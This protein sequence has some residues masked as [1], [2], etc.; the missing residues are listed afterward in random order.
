MKLLADLHTHSTNSRFRHG[1]NSIEEMAIEANEVG[2]VE[3]GVTDHG[4]Q[5]FFRT[6][7]DKL[8]EARKTVDE[9]NK[10]SKTKVLLGVEANII[11][12]DGTL[13]I[14]NETLSLLDI[15]IIGYHRM[16]S[17]NFASFFGFAK[18]TKESKEK[19]TNAFINAIRRYPVTIVAHLDSILETDLYEI[20]KVCRERGTMVEIN[21]RHTKWTE[22]QMEDLIASGCMFVVSSDAHTRDQVGE[23]D[24]AFEYIKK[25]NIPSERVANVKFSEEEKSEADRNFSAYQSVY[26]QLAKTK[27]EKEF[28][29]EKKNRTEITGKLSDEMEDELRKIA[30]EQGLAYQEYKEETVDDEYMKN[31][32]DED[33]ALIKQAEDYIRNK[34]LEEIQKENGVEVVEE[35]TET[36]SFDDNHPLVRESFEEKFQPFNKSVIGI[37]ENEKVDIRKEE[38]NIVI[39]DDEPENANA[40]AFDQ[41]NSASQSKMQMF[42]DIMSSGGEEVVEEEP[43][44]VIPAAT[45][46][47]QKVQTKQVFETVKPENFMESIT[48]TKLVNRGKT[49]TVNEVEEPKAPEKKPAPAPK[50]GRR[51]AL[52]S[53]DS[54][55]GGDKK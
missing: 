19:C 45:A 52:I 26:E 37:E 20:G 6:S 23:V 27:R 30:S 8:K 49:V 55:I 54:L 38:R 22:K 29:I 25:F 31:M 24:N 33:I 39:E 1:K 32:S 2:L 47:Q 12:D 17:T 46:P 40:T 11:S 34:Q 13:D 21:N 44:N 10:W 41:L 50:N 18:K 36:F 5:H 16:T 3:I 35:E 15:L 28:V 48:R 14:D 4:Y 7:K 43:V 42:K 51:G 9:I 53:V